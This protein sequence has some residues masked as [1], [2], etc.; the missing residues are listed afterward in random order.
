MLPG[1][2]VLGLLTDMAGM[3]S[4]AMRMIWM[5]PKK[6]KVMTRWW[7]W[8]VKTLQAEY[9]FHVQ[10][11]VSIRLHVFVY[12]LVWYVIYFMNAAFLHSSAWPE[13]IQIIYYMGMNRHGYVKCLWISHCFLLSSKLKKPKRNLLIIKVLQALP[14]SWKIVQWKLHM[15]VWKKYLLLNLAI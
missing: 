8:I 15:M 9:M 4:T 2:L 7:G 6:H 12:V 10:I 14:K 3:L 5:P 13:D 1:K 11:Q